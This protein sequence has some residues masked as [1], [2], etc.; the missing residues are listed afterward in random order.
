MGVHTES[1]PER[2]IVEWGML[3][4]GCACGPVSV[5]EG[6]ASRYSMGRLP[7]GVYKAVSK[8]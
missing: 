4:T 3:R 6:K 1:V 8:N 5:F 2:R 7:D